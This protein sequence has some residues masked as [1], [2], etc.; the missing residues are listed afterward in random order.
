LTLEG[1]DPKQELDSSSVCL[2]TLPCFLW[3][4]PVCLYYWDDAPQKLLR[5][6]D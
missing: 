5:K 1:L 2:S 4:W 6:L 3:H